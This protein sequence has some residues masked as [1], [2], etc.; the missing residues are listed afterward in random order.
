MDDWVKVKAASERK[1]LR[2]AFNRNV[3]PFSSYYAFEPADLN[4]SI[5]L[6]SKVICLETAPM[7]IFSSK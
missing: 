4:F 5:L 7:S 3:L 6:I 2:T 1:S